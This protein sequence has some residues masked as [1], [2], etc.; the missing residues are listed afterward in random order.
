MGW[1]TPDVYNQPEHFG[2]SIVFTADE[3]DLSYEFN[4]FGVWKDANGA[5]YWAQDAGCSCPSPF[6]DYTDLS[7]LTPGSKEDIVEALAGWYGVTD[8]DKA[9]LAQALYY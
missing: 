1:G 6:E 2:L 7:D 5:L 8:G 3:E 9:D 4:I